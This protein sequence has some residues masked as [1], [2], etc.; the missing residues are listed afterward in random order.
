MASLSNG[1]GK[2]NGISMCQRNI[3]NGSCVATRN[4]A[5]WLAYGNIGVTGR[6]GT[7]QCN[8]SYWRD[9]KRDGHALL[10]T[11]NTHATPRRTM[12]SVT[13]QWP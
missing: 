11:Y 5:K 8:K 12:L 10:H 9:I 13:A 6:A 3:G 2:A 1:C 4:G 7:N